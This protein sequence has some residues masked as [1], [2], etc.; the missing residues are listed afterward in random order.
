MHEVIS[1]IGG[2]WSMTEVDHMKIPGEKIAVNDALIHLRCRIDY[3]LSMDRLWTE[4]RWPHLELL[5]RPTF[6]RPGCLKN[7]PKPVPYWL[8]VFGCDINSTYFND[9]THILNGRNSGAC[10]INLAFV[11]N[12]RKIYLFGFDMC[13]S[14]EGNAYW[15]PPY[16]WAAQHGDKGATSVKR[17]QEWVSDFAHYAQQFKQAGIE[18]VNVSKHSKIL[19]FPQVSPEEVGCAL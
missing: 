8:N 16:P 11:L 13:R 10:A 2:G 5:H 17:Y 14:P 9:D 15:Y 6:V 3:V 12:P 19:A 4:N 1:V 18:V 7:I